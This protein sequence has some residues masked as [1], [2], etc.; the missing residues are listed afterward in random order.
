MNTMNPLHV[1][2]PAHPANYLNSKTLTMKNLRIKCYRL[3]I[4]ITEISDC[5]RMSYSKN[6]PIRIL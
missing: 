1:Y 3:Y 2:E 6:A 5:Y 4:S